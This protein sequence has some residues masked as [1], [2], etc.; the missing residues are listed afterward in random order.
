MSSMFS[1]VELS[2]ENYDA[3]LIG[4]SELELQE[5]V[6]F[7]GGFS[8][9]CNGSEARQYIID[10]FSWVIDDGGLS[11]VSCNTTN[12]R[13][14]TAYKNLISIIDIL[15]RETNSKGFNIEVYDDGSFEKKYVIK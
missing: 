10:T 12:I 2:T 5:N 6:N 9:Y 15:R 8:Q 4:W 7:D 3:I 13:E 14:Q 11:D 1:D